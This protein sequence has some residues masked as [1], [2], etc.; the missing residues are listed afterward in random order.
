MLPPILHLSSIGTGYKI[1]RHASFTLLWCCCIELLCIRG[2]LDTC[3]SGLEEAS[4]LAAYK[5]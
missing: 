5:A 1:P 2:E 3:N 4:L